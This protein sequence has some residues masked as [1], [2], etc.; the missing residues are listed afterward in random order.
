MAVQVRCPNGEIKTREA[1]IKCQKCMPDHIIDSILPKDREKKPTEKPRFGVTRL[2]DNCLRKS[3][4]TLTE[5]SILDLKRHWVF[6]RGHA[7]HEYITRTLA[8]EHKEVFIKKEFPTFELLGFIDALKNGILYEFKT[9]S[10]IPE[11]PHEHHVLQAQAY[12]SMLPPEKQNKIE[13]IQIVY[14]NLSDI[15]TFDVPTRDI[16]K[17]LRAKGAILAKALKEKAPPNPVQS[18]LCNY[19]E[20]KEAC[21]EYE[22]TII[23]NYQQSSL[24][25]F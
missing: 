9:T 10:T 17:L 14:L 25:R 18:W 21:D 8:D 19:C 1:C 24:V 23:G 16:T 4:Y 6:N 2:V 13:K 7:I 12:F 11:E 22:R 5:E 20:F 15:K 3:Y